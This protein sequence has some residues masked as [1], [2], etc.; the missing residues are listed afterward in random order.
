MLNSV[1]ACVASVAILSPAVIA[2]DITLGVG[3]KAPTLEHVEWIKGEPV[4]EFEEGQ[5]YV[6]DFWA[7]WCSPC[8]ASIPHI[9]SLQ[10]LHKDDNVNVIGVAVWP[11]SR[12][13]PTADFVE[14]R[15]DE[16][17]YRVASDIDRK[18]SDAYM[19]ASGQG[20]IPTV[21]VIDKT[22]EIA[23][24]GHPTVPEGGLDTVLD[25]LVKDEFS[26]ERLE[27]E[28]KQLVAEE[29]AR[30]ARVGEVFTKYKTAE[31]AGNWSGVEDAL[32]ELFE[33]NDR[34]IPQFGRVLYVAKAKQDKMED[35]R[36]F[37]AD[38]M[39][40]VFKNDADALDIMAWTIVGPNSPLTEE[41]T[42]T[43]LAITMAKKAAEL[44]SDRS[45]SIQDTLARAYF[46]DGQLGL[47]VTTQRKAVEMSNNQQDYVD[48]LEQYEEAASQS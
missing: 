23:W 13:K 16:M 45:A 41:Q 26:P 17:D 32:T 7:T 9:N 19:T 3:D 21:M 4:T 46:V 48:R 25:L 14:E 18:T 5:I 6:L 34:F 35:A 22:G 38:L 42:D 31:I 28:M 36:K 8:V 12:M 24:I 30:Q 33:I 10:Q 15:G 39:T 2:Q 27:A 40:S 44:T 11:N 37:A 29:Q 43:E 47:A 1:F 20:G